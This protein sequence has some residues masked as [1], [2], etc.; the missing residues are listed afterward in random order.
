MSPTE[1]EEKRLIQMC[2]P[3]Y[4]IQYTIR[5]YRISYTI[6]IYR[7]QSTIF[8][9]NIQSTIH[10]YRIQYEMNCIRYE[11]NC[12]QYMIHC[13][14]AST[15]RAIFYTQVFNR[16]STK[17]RLSEGPAGN[18]RVADQSPACYHEAARAVYRHVEKGV[19]RPFRPARTSN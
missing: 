2:Y 4:R 5:S 10:R 12:I 1:A 18:V 9:Y 7:I 19:Y 13:M 15:I 6:Y 14:Y 11:M 8:V 17:R 3:V 16:F